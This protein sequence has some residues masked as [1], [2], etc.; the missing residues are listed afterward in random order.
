MITTD[1]STLFD[2]DRSKLPSIVA[3]GSYALYVALL[4]LDE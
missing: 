2:V 4:E 1:V 3:E